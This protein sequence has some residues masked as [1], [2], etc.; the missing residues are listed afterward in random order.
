MTH[1]TNGPLWSQLTNQRNNVSLKAE[2][3]CSRRVGRHCTVCMRGHTWPLC[4]I[5]A[6]TSGHNVSTCYATAVRAQTQKPS[7]LFFLVITVGWWLHLRFF[8]SF[9]DFMFYFRPKC[10][11]ATLL[12]EGGGDV[13]QSPNR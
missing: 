3:T 1:Q 5:G 8:F 12:Q 13:T 7:S 10:C 4:R 6:A 11:F 2:L 9:P